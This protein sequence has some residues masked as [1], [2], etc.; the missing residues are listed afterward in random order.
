MICQFIMLNIRLIYFYLKIFFFKDCFI[1]IIDYYYY[2]YLDL[3][4]IFNKNI[5]FDIKLNFIFLK[6]EQKYM[7]LFL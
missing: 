2:Y 6:K 3:S 5:Y 7:Y 1:N 4:L